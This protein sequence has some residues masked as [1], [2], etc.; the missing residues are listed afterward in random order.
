MKKFYPLVCVLFLLFYGF[1]FKA[2]VSLYAFSQTVVPYSAITGGT[3]FGSP[4]TDDE[5]FLNTAAPLGAGVGATGPGMPIGF[6]FLFD[7]LV[8]DRVGINANGFIYLGQSTVTPNVDSWVSNAFAPISATSIALP[9]RQYK[10]V[11]FGMDIQS[12]SG[13]NAHIRMQTIGTAPSRTAVI[14]W[15]N[16]RKYNNVGDDFNFQI[17]LIET[18]NVVEVIYGSFVNNAT[19]GVAQVGLRG[20]APN[21]Y[22]NRFVNA[23]NVWSVSAVGNSNTIIANFNAGLVPTTGLV[24]RW[25]P[26]P[27][28]TGAPAANSVVSSV[29]SICPFGTAS[30]SLVNPYTN[31]GITYQWEVS[32]TSS[33]GP[34]FPVS[35]SAGAF[36]NPN[37]IVNNTWYRC[38]I[39]C[40]T[41]SLSTQ[42]AP[43]QV[44]TT[45]AA[46]DN[47]PYNEGF[48][49]LILNNQY[50]NCSWAASQ[51]TTVCQTYT[52]AASNNRTPHSGN[53]FGV[54]K[55]PTNPLGDYFY[56]GGIQLYSGIT[57]SASTWFTTD[58][59]FGW[60]NFAMLYG[61]AQTSLNLTP[62][63][64]TTNIA[65]GFLYSALSNT[66][67]V[68]SSGVYLLAIK[69]I[70][71][72]NAQ[73]LSFDDISITI[74][75]SLNPP[76][77][78]LVPS[79]TV[80]CEGQG[81]LITPTSTN[82]L[83]YGNANPTGT[84]LAYPTPN[85]VYSV[86][87]SNTLTG[88]I[89]S[90]TISIGVNPTPAVSIIS[91]SAIVC[92]G[93]SVV[94]NAYGAPSY[95]WNTGQS[96]ASVTVKPQV[97]TVYSVT[98]SNNFGCIGGNS[99][100]IS[101][102]PS[103]TVL[104]TII[105]S[106]ICKGEIAL[107][108]ASGALSYT[109]TTIPNIYVGGNFTLTPQITS[110][111]DVAGKASNGCIGRKTVM[112]TVDE[113]TGLVSQQQPAGLQIYPNPFEQKFEVVCHLKG[114][115]HLTVTDASGKVLFQ[116]KS[117]EER[118]EINLS[119]FPSGLYFI[120]IQS[121]EGVYFQ[122]L[123]KT[124]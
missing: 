18:S 30:L 21:D 117:E 67:S 112:V 14:Q 29:G 118:Q 68:S 90:N 92:K 94:M 36:Y 65:S 103:P 1:Q 60:N 13:L 111:F 113:C 7:G 71:S 88:C 35:G 23:I 122:K 89:Q 76:N 63:A 78:T 55:A 81:V 43:F 20:A 121:K 85:N 31:S 38:V 124:L 34:Y 44:L 39:T 6:N 82:S 91:P 9:T 93:D 37:N 40:A 51:P 108:Q 101:V 42:A 97:A 22:S 119:A 26:P 70:S 15:T 48:E 5:V 109:W 27:P 87:G 28:C 83:F 110:V 116:N 24:Y 106:I 2:Q 99:I 73:Y 17:R 8:F 25:V 66:F 84:I 10:V 53:K 59:T 86:T 33:T 98:G 79:A 12:Q 52:V 11:A 50:P 105:P 58:G 80:V 115:K 72:G 114:M 75:C 45:G 61:T 19:G 123:V 62:I 54:F 57:Y 100:S 102:I 74:P 16:Y 47:V 4:T 69:G 95:S 120:Q 77:F 96:T 107:F 104:A 3:A 49:S 32:G 64:S 46:I 56:T 41:S